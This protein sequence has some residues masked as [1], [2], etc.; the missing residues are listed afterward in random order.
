ML[1][2][3]LALALALLGASEPV[4]A[5]AWN[6]LATLAPEQELL[7]PL[8]KTPPSGTVPATWYALRIDGGAL[9]IQPVTR[10]RV[11]RDVLTNAMG[12]PRQPAPTV[13][14]LALPKDAWMA[15]QWRGEGKD[16]WLPPLV[17]RH[18]NALPG[19]ALLTA[20]WRQQV[21]LRQA[22]GS[23]QTWTL[24]TDIERRPDGH[25]L[26]GSLQ[27]MARSADASADLVLLPIAHGMAFQRQ[28][29]LWV[30]LLPGDRKPSFVLKRTWLT[31][32]EEHVVVLNGLQAIERRDT[33]A[34]WQIFRSGADDSAGSG[35]HPAEQTLPLPTSM[36]EGGQIRFNADAWN[37]AL[38]EA[39]RSPLTPRRIARQASAI[40]G[41]PLEVWVDYVPRIDSGTAAAR[42]QGSSATDTPW[43]GAVVMQLKFRGRTSVLLELDTLEEPLGMGVG[44][45]SGGTPAISMRHTPHYN[46][47]FNRWWIWDD[48]AGR[49]RRWLIEHSQGC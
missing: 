46:N 8:P 40:H 9:D 16:I 33:D 36:T 20:Q 11:S 22:D 18:A 29:L 28:E 4:G 24:F 12:E 30:G 45:V 25:L 47:S 41:E 43:R 6:R 32:E 31:G 19:T 37:Q 48:K 49:F 7:E 13:Q 42:H 5:R 27:L 15:V 17:G 21:Q 38:E 34:P 35:R 23:E 1:R 14:T 44:H 39:Q 26:A 10:A 2:G 3:V